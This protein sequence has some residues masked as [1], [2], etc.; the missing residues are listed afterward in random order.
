MYVYKYTYIYTYT[1]IY[2]ECLYVSLLHNIT[3]NTLVVLEIKEADLDHFRQ[4]KYQLL[5]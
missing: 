1:H 3:F 4:Q 5:L 2:C